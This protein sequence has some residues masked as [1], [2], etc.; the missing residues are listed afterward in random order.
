MQVA[1]LHRIGDVLPELRALSY[2]QVDSWDTLG[3]ISFSR[4]AKGS[5]R[6]RGLSEIDVRRLKL[7]DAWLDV[8]PLGSTDGFHT[9]VIGLLWKALDYEVWPNELF[10]FHDG[11][12]WVCSEVFP[13]GRGS[14]LTIEVWALA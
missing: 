12:E 10:V 4:P 6:R 14:H 1:E 11:F 7:I 9:T 3:L 2:R 8:F 5:G 13:E